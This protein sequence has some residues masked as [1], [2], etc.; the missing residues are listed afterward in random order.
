MISDFWL[1]LIKATSIS[2]IHYL[3][4]WLWLRRESFFSLN[5]WYLLLSLVFSYS[6]P[7]INIRVEKPV[8]TIQNFA[9]QWQYALNQFQFEPYEMQTN[10]QTMIDWNTILF[11]LYLA[12]SVV[13]AIR[14]IAHLL[15]IAHDIRTHQKVKSD[16]HT[17][18][19]TSKQPSFS[20]FRF[21][22]L[23]KDFLN[24]S[25]GKTI[26]KHESVHVQ[27]KHSFDRMFLELLMML[28]W[29][30][31]LLM[32]YKRSLIEVHEL[33]AD[34]KTTSEIESIQSYYNLVLDL[35]YC[36]RH[37][38]FINHFSYQQLKKRIKMA[39][40][41]SNPYKKGL[42]IFPILI[43][44]LIFGIACIDI[45]SGEENTSYIDNKNWPKTDKDKPDSTYFWFEGTPLQ[46]KKFGENFTQILINWKNEILVGIKKGEIQDIKPFVT[47]F[48]TQNTNI[49]EILLAKDIKCYNDFSNKVLQE[50]LEAYKD[51]RNKLALEKFSKPYEDCNPDSKK[52]IE[53]QYPIMIHFEHKNIGPTS[54]SA[55][56]NSKPFIL[57][58]K[59]NEIASIPASWGWRIHPVYKIKKF[60]NAIDYKAELNTKIIAI[61]NGIVREVQSDTTGYGN[62]L[63]IDHD[64]GFSS[65]YAHV[66]NFKVEA[67][68]HVKQGDIIAFVGN[69]G[70]STAPHLHLE[71]MKNGENINP[72]SVIQN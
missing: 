15:K 4:Y 48:L 7:L 57:P 12:I 11:Y 44:T 40:H 3:F 16:E 13:F 42:I 10:H 65:L 67:G 29:C 59:E 52:A 20:F 54:N 5:R 14:I 45:N 18:V 49:K 68:H 60:H 36:R 35:A 71:I 66:N 2:A 55:N 34:R 64:N 24:T 6:V 50:V 43:A 46:K 56:L 69:T 61:G 72:S 28:S 26:I 62:Y 1:Y 22:F 37:S 32:F 33:Q 19:I 30:N 21:I 58:I 25:N 51:V 31:P 41:H 38:P 39:T 23:S 9:P 17:I 47:T 27:Q 8:D 53:N 63:I 70:M